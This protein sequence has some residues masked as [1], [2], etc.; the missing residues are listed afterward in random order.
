MRKKIIWLLGTIMLIERIW[1]YVMV[2]R[3]F[4]R[5]QTE[6]P[7]KPTLVTILQP[8][9]GGDP[10]M[11]VCL[12]RSLRL[13]SQYALEYIWVADE[14]DPIG[15][16]VCHDLIAGYPEKHIRLLTVPPPPDGMNP[17]AFKLIEGA[18]VMRGDIVCVLDDDTMLPDDGLEQCLPYLEEPG[19]GL[20]FGLPYYVNYSNH[21]S[22]MVSTFVNSNSLLTYIPYTVL[23]QPFTVNGMF[24]AI[25]RP[26]LDAIGGFAA[27]GHM[28]SDDFAIAH[29]MRTHGYQLAQTPLRHAISTQVT[30][31]RHYTS[32]LQRWFVFPRESLLRHV[33]WKDQII[34]YILG[35][36]PAIWP[37]LLIFSL[38][39]RPSLRTIRYTLLYFGI[40]YAIV[41][42]LNKRYLNQ[43][44]PVHR[45]WWVPVVQIVF[46]IQLIAA[47]LSSQRAN[48]RGNIVQVERGGT[49][50]YIQ[51]RKQSISTDA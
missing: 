18:R 10:T 16:S 4:Q 2:R 37:L 40:T 14:D 26:V 39:L 9:L 31:M 15:L 25:K 36:A 48:W 13:R 43:S 44:I 3:F 47:L 38:L 5:S 29:V 1:K 30:G 41:H 23:T 49:F 20:A 7:I 35:L 8:V 22:S 32:L 12:E 24:Y 46:P 42:D 19:V 6:A 51:R 11:S 34:V 45:S 17:K 28:F 27:I 33:S 50:R 21:W